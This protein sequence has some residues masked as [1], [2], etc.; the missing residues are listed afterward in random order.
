MP[1]NQ[2]EDNQAMGQM[3]GVTYGKAK[4]CSYRQKNL[5]YLLNCNV[6]GKEKN[7][8]PHENKITTRCNGV[9][10]EK[11]MQNDQRDHFY[12]TEK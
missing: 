11:N 7:I 10:P 3:T 12:S 2:F 4:S 5:K 9:N 8:F 1:Y 6:D